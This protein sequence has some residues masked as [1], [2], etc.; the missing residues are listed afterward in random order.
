MSNLHGHSV[1]VPQDLLMMD[2]GRLWCSQGWRSERKSRD[3]CIPAWSAHMG[4]GKKWCQLGVMSVRLYISSPV[5]TAS[6]RGYA[7]LAG[8]MGWWNFDRTD[9]YWLVRYVLLTCEFSHFL[10]NGLP[11]APLI[12]CFPVFPYWVHAVGGIACNSDRNCTAF[13][14]THAILCSAFWAHSF[15]MG[16]VPVLCIGEYWKYW[17]SQVKKKRRYILLNQK[18]CHYL[19]Y[20]TS[21]VSF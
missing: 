14:L 8:P 19:D 5:S 12:W 2:N 15:C 4:I 16:S 11:F 9:L 10:L 21:L 18:I 1:P 17:Y 13:L 7:S 6:G 3:A 20:S